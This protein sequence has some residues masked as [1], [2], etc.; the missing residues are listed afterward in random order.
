VSFRLD[1]DLSL[2]GHSRGSNFGCEFRVSF[3][4]LFLFPILDPSTLRELDENA[5]YCMGG[6]EARCAG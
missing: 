1:L 5:S 6:R 4:F 3:L 2:L